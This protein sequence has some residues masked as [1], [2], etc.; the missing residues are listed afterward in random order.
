MNNRFTALVAAVIVAIGS[1]AYA[2]FKSSSQ[3]TG[4]YTPPAGS[5]PNPLGDTDGDGI[6]DGTDTDDDNDGFLDTADAFPLDA[7]EWVDTDNDLIGNNADTDDDND[8]ILD[9][10][11]A[12]PLDGT[13]SV[14]ALD[15]STLTT[16]CTENLCIVRGV[17]STGTTSVTVTG[18]HATA[19][20]EIRTASPLASGDNFELRFE[21]LTSGA[22]TFQVSATNASGQ[23]VLASAPQGSSAS[24]AQAIA[25]AIAD[26]ANP[27]TVTDV[28][29]SSLPAQ[30]QG[31]LLAGASCGADG[32]RDCL[33]WFNDLTAT[34][35][36]AGVTGAS[37][38]AEVETYT[39]CVLHE[40][41]VALIDAAVV[42]TP[43]SI[44][45]GCSNPDPVVFGLP[46]LCSVSQISC[47]V[48]G[49]PSSWTVNAA[50]TS[51][52]VPVSY[53][54]GASGSETINATVGLAL[55]PRYNTRGYSYRIPQTYN[56]IPTQAG[57]DAQGRLLRV[58]T[59]GRANPMTA[60]QTCR[61]L[62]GEL[63]S[64][65]QADAFTTN[66]GTY[67]FLMYHPTGN[68]EDL[69]WGTQGTCPYRNGGDDRCVARDGA[70]GAQATDCGYKVSE[71]RPHPRYGT[72]VMVQVDV[73]YYGF[74]WD[75]EQRVTQQYCSGDAGTDTV[76][77]NDS[78]A[79]VCKDLPACE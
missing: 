17:A 77:W 38:N 53:I 1:S 5:T 14:A 72:A 35:T 74:F 19:T 42:P 68:D 79:F 31:D 13:Q 36:C 73:R 11:D 30:L 76:G 32:S 70:Y 44:V 65:T 55:A 7:G 16:Q 27:I 20:D 78:I 62:G 28:Q 8:G 18:S 23:I 45:R 64:K 10:A 15:V 67:S 63:A 43:E 50:E 59:S 58:V 66:T 60:Q 6:P 29:N 4:A 12:F 49:A 75:R 40:G 52:T 51:L 41:Y 37:S 21:S 33:A 25:D 9:L 39:N 56:V 54:T 34:T 2:G 57:V 71:T 47:T 69:S 22:W 24:L 3:G 61:N 46:S 48:D 26:P